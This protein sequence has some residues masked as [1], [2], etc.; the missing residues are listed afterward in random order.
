MPR[1]GAGISA[2]MV[3]GN[4]LGLILLVAGFAGLIAALG[5]LRRRSVAEALPYFSRQ[6]L[7]S[8]GELAFYHALRQALP[9]GVA[10]SFKVRL[11][12]LINC[13]GSAW[14]AGYGARISQKHIDFVIIDAGSTRIL[15]AVELDD[16]THRQSIRRE[17][18]AFVDR[19]LEA[20]GVPILRVAAAAAYNPSALRAE[21]SEF[22]DGDVSRRRP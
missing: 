20:A 22:L 4:A 13:S 14:K 11:S 17:R 15:L 5:W 12:D 16:R 21:V 7:L 2:T 19:A 18:D 9:E 6:T 8:R 3:S 10:V 1:D